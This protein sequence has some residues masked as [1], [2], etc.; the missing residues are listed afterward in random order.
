MA[1]DTTELSLASLELEKLEAA[2][3]L[4]FFAAHADGVID[5]SERAAFEAHVAKA[6]HGQLRPEI[7][8]AVLAH[9][10]ATAPSADRAARLA[11]IS[12]RIV[13]PR[14]RRAVLALAATVAH[15]D[16]TLT[17]AERAFLTEAAAVFGLTSEELAPLIAAP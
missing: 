14:V 17:E 3:E 5:P 15:A 2:V 1:N 16:G 13:D 4:M 7:V 11:A 6:T 10:E 9:F 8:R 12:K